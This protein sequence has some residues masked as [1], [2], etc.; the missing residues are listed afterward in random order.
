MPQH[1]G[2][3]F[4]TIIMQLFRA[5]LFGITCLFASIITRAACIPS[6]TKLVGWYKGETNT[7]DEM[8][9][10]R[11]NVRGA[12]TFVNGVNGQSF[13]FNGGNDG[14]VLTDNTPFRLQEFTIEAWIRRSR[15]DIV[16]DSPGGCAIFS[17]GVGGYSLVMTH[18]G[19]PGLSHVGA[20]RIDGPRVITDTN[21]HHVA[22]SRSDKVVRIYV[23]G[24]LVQEGVQNVT[25]TFDTPFAIGSMGSDIG[26][27]FYSFIGDIDEIS[28]YSG[29]L[30]ES[31][32][33]KIFNAGSEGK[34]PIQTNCETPN[35]L[36]AYWSAN[37]A[38]SD[39]LASIPGELVGG[40]QFVEGVSGSAFRFDGQSDGVVIPDSQRL[41]LQNFSIAMWMRRGDLARTSYNFD[42]GALFAGG[43]GSYALTI[44]NDGTLCISKV[45]VSRSCA[46]PAVTDLNWHHVAISKVDN[47]V[48]FFLDGIRRSRTT[49]G[50]TFEF[51]MPFGIGSLGGLVQGLWA[52]FWGDIDDVAIYSRAVSESEMRRLAESHQ[53]PVCLQDIGIQ[54]TSAP[55]LVKVSED[56]PFKL[57]ITNN[58]GQP[59]T[60]VRIQWP[61]KAG[62]S[63]VRS[64]IPS[65]ACEVQDSILHCDL[66]LLPGFS[67]LDIEFVHRFSEA[68]PIGHEVTVSRGE[69]DAS[70]E[71][72]IAR[73]P[74]TVIGSC[75]PPLPG[76]VAR[77]SGEGNIW[78]TFG[79]ATAASSRTPFGPGV[80]SGQAFVFNDDPSI[81]IVDSASLRPPR[82]TWSMWVK[83]SSYNINN[84]VLLSHQ[85]ASGHGLHTR[86]EIQ[87]NNRAFFPA[88]SLLFGIGVPDWPNGPNALIGAASTLPLGEWTHVALTYETNGTAMVYVN[89]IATRDVKVAAQLAPSFGNEP[90]ILNFGGPGPVSL[91]EITLYDRPLS[92]AEVEALYQVKTRLLCRNDLAVSW[93]DVPKTMIAGHSESLA[94]AVR[95]GGTDPVNSPKL[96]LS[97]AA[98]LPILG[99]MVNGTGCP[100]NNGVVE[101]TIGDL[102]P[103]AE[104]IVRVFVRAD[105]KPALHNLSAIVSSTTPDDGP[106]NN[107][108]TAFIEILA[109][110]QPVDHL[111]A[112]WSFENSWTERAQGLT[113]NSN[114]VGLFVP[115]RIGQ[116]VQF[117]VNF[118]LLETPLPDLPTN[119]FTVEGW[120]Q[121]LDAARSSQSDAF[122]TVIGSDGG[123]WNFSLSHE[124]AL[125]FGSSGINLVESRPVITD[126]GWHH[127]AVT[128]ADGL[129]TLFADGEPV[130]S[131]PY[132][133]DFQYPN[134]F[135]I[136]QTHTTGAQIL[137]PLWANLDEMAVYSEALSPAQI[138]AIHRAGSGGK[139]FQDL[140]LRV[141]PQAASVDAG[142]TFKLSFDVTNRGH[143]IAP[144]A[145]L[146]MEVPE[147]YSLESFSTLAV[148]AAFQTDLSSVI[149]Q[150]R[151]RCQNEG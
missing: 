46:G 132:A 100:I 40:T 45:G 42:E 70:L 109:D 142:A 89:G 79:S 111:I 151:T 1:K 43:I 60:A 74:T 86:L 36:V 150:P 125:M 82:F 147:G 123:A 138:R 69:P 44:H 66:G 7:A 92:A 94:V 88:G 65:G 124:G 116:A 107:T 77:W 81:P 20:S 146:H 55:R 73:A 117:G 19:R 41:Q 137:N 141:D 27:I 110:C 11:G 26:G 68:N 135:N 67:S 106:K 47:E 85:T 122:G 134:P 9:L 35:G 34:C 72:N 114:A 39:H 80:D 48:T 29:A 14:I 21:W 115:G 95:N 143:S 25:Y 18:D 121:R 13:H 104:S 32:I 75:L 133:F 101:C 140:L 50:Q 33:Q 2:S 24:K 63:L 58:G 8:T 139:C 144:G 96:R 12:P 54:F 59:A 149:W 93:V 30:V 61:L 127:V 83:P 28:M 51:G 56:T 102:S 148:P 91:D 103:N 17:S 128:L 120:I 145:R 37:N 119:R 105:G 87:G 3:A 64:S 15:T 130:F 38:T 131:K 76:L 23:D 71:N 98:G 5:I 10:G 136:G 112:W 90:G 97:S 16:S 52:S 118:F 22:V 78:D 6:T 49:F 126:L 84:S 113:D 53:P 31:D 62:Q 99:A 4:H 57:R 108:A 129:L